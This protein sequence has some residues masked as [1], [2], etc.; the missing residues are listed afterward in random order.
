MSRNYKLWEIHERICGNHAGGQSLAHKALRQGYF[1]LAMK[2]DAMA[3]VRKCYKCQ[4]FSNIP[5]SHL[6][7]LTSMVSLWPFVV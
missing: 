3:F 4:R 6:E 5:K 2:I 7:K 1:W